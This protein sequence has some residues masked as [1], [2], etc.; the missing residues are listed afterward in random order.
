MRIVG[1][2]GATRSVILKSDEGII[3]SLSTLNQAINRRRG[4]AARP[5][6]PARRRPRVEG[7]EE[8]CLLAVNITEVPNLST[9]VWITVGPDATTQAATSVMGTDATL[10]ASANP[11]GSPTAAGVVYGTDPNL[12]SGTTTAVTTLPATAITNT[13]ATLGG[14][15]NPNGSSTDTFFQWSDD[16]TLP[17][18]VVTTLAGSAGVAG[19]ADGTGPAALF[20][21]LQAVAV[22]ATGN[23]YVADTTS[24]TIRK[25]TPAGVVTTIAGTANQTGSTDG[26]GAAALFNKPAGIAVDKAGNVYVADTSNDTIRK[27]TSAG[28]VTTIAGSPGLEGSAN[29]TGAAARFSIP[30][31]LAVD[32]AGNVYVADWG[33]ETIRKITPAGVV[34]T[35]AGTV[36]VSGSANGQGTAATFD[37]PSGVAVDGTGNVYVA[38]ASNDT[39]RKIDPT[40]LVSTFAGTAGNA[41]IADGTGSA[42][43]FFEPLDVAVD[44][45]GNVYVADSQA[46]LIRKITP[47]AVVTTLAGS[48]TGSANGIGHQAQFN[49]PYSVTVDGAGDVYVADTNN[50]TV[51]KL[52]IPTVAAQTGL[53]GTAALAV[54]AGLTG[55]TQGTTYYFRVGAASGNGMAVGQTLSF[56]TTAA[57]APSATAK[58]ATSITATTATLHGTVTPN[59]SDTTVVFEYAPDQGA[60]GNLL[61]T[62]P[63]HIGAGTAPVNVSAVLSGL[64]PNTRY[65]FTVAATNDWGTFRP[66]GLTFTTAKA[67]APLATTATLAAPVPNPSTAGQTVTFTASVKAVN[68]S[69]PPAGERVVFT[70]GSTTVGTALLNGTGHA[71]LRTATLAV[72]SHTVRAHFG[73][74]AAYA[75]S[76]PSNAVTAVVQAA[77]KV[78]TSLQELSAAPNP[79]TFGQS[80]TFSVVVAPA[81]TNGAKA[82]AVKTQQAAVPGGFVVFVLDGHNLTPTRVT[83]ANGASVATLIDANLTVGTHTLTARYSGDAT[84]AASQVAQPISVTVQPVAAGG[85]QV[86]KVQRFGYHRFPTTLVLTFDQPLDPT[87]AQD[88]ANYTLSGGGQRS[89]PIVSAVYHAATQTVTLRPLFLLPLRDKFVLQVN[90]EAPSGL[91]NK[92]G[93]FLQGA[94]LGQPGTNFVTLITR[95]NLVWTTGGLP[96]YAATAVPQGPAGLAS[97]NTR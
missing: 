52:S 91:T 82:G 79:S 29:G 7:L 61:K 70:E 69:S 88:V 12:A 60:I 68:G 8:R 22:D 30:K 9:P 16:P 27:I 31:G 33:N 25:V 80:V 67:S 32:D 62:S 44:T 6:V 15:V 53:T 49:D 5:N 77:A 36:D 45:A 65:F 96:V 26:T 48:T 73:G 95:A 28:V 14:T 11:Q 13:S 97:A 42:A 72:G 59:G 34:T 10:N 76:G 64:D 83:T 86:M 93:Q 58:P 57:V 84:Y 92:S 19:T 46:N 75:A 56:T 54:N 78:P 1:G 41:G 20:G 17:A 85:P 87:R 37:R 81:A 47:A 43:Q 55:L 51:R 18:N 39:I 74:D 35:L 89:V 63:Q 3:M 66:N 21:Q 23:V 40:G 4:R 94:G 24:S 50:F 2:P 90:G 71:T 38:D